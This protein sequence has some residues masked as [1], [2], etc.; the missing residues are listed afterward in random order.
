MFI[1]MNR[2]RIV[3]GQEEA[4]EEVWRGRDSRL[5][6]VPGFE[7]FHLLK[8]SEAEDHVLYAS[9]TIWRDR[10]AF[11]DWTHSDAFRQAHK[12]AG[13]TRGMYLGGPQVPGVDVVLEMN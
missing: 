12:D 7:E 4:F 13:Q 11:E 6:D 10:A 9:H 2:F 3:K 5:K 1:A 8:G